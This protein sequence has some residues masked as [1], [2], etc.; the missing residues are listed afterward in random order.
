[1]FLNDRQIRESD[2]FNQEYKL[3]ANTLVLH[4]DREFKKG[5]LFDDT[6]E[7]L[8]EYIGGFEYPKSK[9]FWSREEINL[10]NKTIGIVF[11]R[12]KMA[13][14]GILVFPGFIHPG[15]NGRILINAVCLGSKIL[16][17]KNLEIAYI[18]FAESNPIENAFNLNNWYI[19][20]LGIDDPK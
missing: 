19:D 1:M 17:E 14:N 13:A 5:K 15:F 20:S 2:F 16:I 8:G 11:G 10:D 7:F 18:A 3:V 6:D 12:Q 9:A 4:I